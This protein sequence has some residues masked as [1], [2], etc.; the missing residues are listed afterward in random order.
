MNNIKYTWED[1]EKA[2]KKKD[3]F[4]ALH[5]YRRLGKIFAYVFLNGFKVK[6][7]NYVTILSLFV[8]LL[9]LVVSFSNLTLLWKILIIS[10]LYFLYF[11]LDCTDGIIARVTNNTTEFGK[12]LDAFIDGRVEDLLFLS[13]IL[14][15]PE[16]YIKFFWLICWIIRKID[17]LMV[18]KYK[19]SFYKHIFDLIFSK[20]DRN[21][22]FHIHPSDVEN[23]LF[24]ILAVF[25]FV[26]NN[27][28]ILVVGFGSYVI[29]SFLGDIII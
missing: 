17:K 28:I 16:T 14:I 6:N 20:L 7:P 27:D 21:T 13:L 10:I 8:G 1:I 12:K 22:N 11:S 5:I 26:F 9:F 18:E 25:S 24:L 4:F 15:F 3:G 23:I 2:N 19:D 29:L